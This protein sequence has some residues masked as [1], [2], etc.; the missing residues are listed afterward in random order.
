[1]DFQDVVFLPCRDSFSTTFLKNGGRGEGLGTTT[2]L[3]TV[4]WGKQ[5]HAPFKLL[6]LQQCLFL[7]QFNLTVM[8][9]W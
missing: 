4:V 8:K 7:C 3:I 9:L 6:T 5:G 1:M 2:C